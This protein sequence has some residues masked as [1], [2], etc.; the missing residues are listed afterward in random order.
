MQVLRRFT[1]DQR[2]VTA[3]LFGLAALPI[4]GSV[5]AAVDY[6][7]AASYHSRMQLG[8]DATAV[9]IVRSP[10]S[11][12]GR[13]IQQKGEQYLAATLRSDPTAKLT[14]V[15]VTRTG[16]TVRVAATAT[17]DTAVMRLFGINTMPLSTVAQATWGSEETRIELALVLDNTGSMNDGIGG[18]RRKIDE[19]ISASQQ[20]LKDLRREATDRDSIKVSV[21]PFDTEVRLDAN[22]NRYKP[23]FRWENE[24]RDRPAWTGY[25]IDRYGT[26]A[27]ND[28]APSSADRGSL[29]PALRDSE[30]REG[31]RM[32]DIS[33]A[34]L[35]VVRPLTS[36]QSY[37]DY[38]ELDRAIGAMRPRGYTNLAIGTSWGMAT[39]SNSEPFSE[40]SPAGTPGLRKI[41]LLL[42]DGL[43]TATHVDG[44]LRNALWK[45]EAERDRMVRAM[46]ETTLA[47]CASAK[48]SGVEIYTVRLVEGDA[49]VLR[50]CASQAGNYFD[51]QR[52]GDLAKAFKVFQSGI[53]GTRLTH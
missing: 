34:D 37:S 2:G 35:P 29:Y 9:A 5:G 10:S 19:L 20:L 48:A 41:M 43:N 45:S 17:M 3:M 40:A 1:A 7:R 8:A 25:V 47:A 30:Y 33:R 11:L 32:G 16:D 52:S 27:T 4:L 44:E 12:N 6:S 36:L 42:T 39:L 15:S 13:E 18:G 50:S 14:S 24:T 23:W 26:Y 51:V 38:Q 31:N 22:A 21:V 46:N 49:D 53:M 28:K